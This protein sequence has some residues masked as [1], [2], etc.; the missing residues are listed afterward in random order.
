MER[1][2]MLPI[3]PGYI[4]F[5]RRSVRQTFRIG[6]ALFVASILWL[7]FSLEM[8][9]VL[10]SDENTQAYLVLLPFVILLIAGL[11]FLGIWGQFHFYRWLGSYSYDDGD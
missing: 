1:F 7:V 3:P 9:A 2:K 5:T 10:T 8:D 4:K 11:G 6:A